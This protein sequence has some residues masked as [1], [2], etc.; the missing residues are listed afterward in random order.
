MMTRVNLEVGDRVVVEFP[1]R[2][3]RYASLVQGVGD[4][5]IRLAAPTRKGELVR[6]KPEE[7]LIVWLAAP[8]AVYGFDSVTLALDLAVQPAL[9]AT[10]PT[11]VRRVQRRENVREW[12]SI[13]PRLVLLDGEAGTTRISAIILNIS[14]SGVL[15]STPVALPAGTRLWLAFPLPG[16]P[17]VEACA[18]VVRVQEPR[19][20]GASSY[21]V[22]ACFTQ[23][24]HRST[25]AIVRAIYR[26]QVG[27]RRKETARSR[28]DGA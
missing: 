6:P 3:D 13:E 16:G 18:E 26:M 10:L 4:G 20:T 9:V 28:T 23:V 21:R 12:I 22:A 17:E 25:Q 24:S 7:R 2:G 8:D 15:L 14:A 11:L 5:L 19:L 27:R 1:D